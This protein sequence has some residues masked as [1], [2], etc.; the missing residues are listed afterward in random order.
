MVIEIANLAGLILGLMP[1]I[2]R[3]S[4]SVPMRHP[5]ST[6]RWMNPVTVSGTFRLRIS[7]R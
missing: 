2:V 7:L 6:A 1:R 4:I 5:A 3:V